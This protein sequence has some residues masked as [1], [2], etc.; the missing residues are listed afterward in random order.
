MGD[1]PEAT[2]N[3]KLIIITIA[4]CLYSAINQTTYESESVDVRLKH[5]TVEIAGGIYVKFQ[6]NPLIFGV[7][8][9]G[10]MNVSTVRRKSD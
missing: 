1:Q 3:N 5:R 8:K 7:E 10:G 9:H 6:R 2:D 4:Y